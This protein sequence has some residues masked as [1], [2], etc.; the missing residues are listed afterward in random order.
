M[1][2]DSLD[3]TMHDRRFIYAGRGPS[4]VRAPRRTASAAGHGSCSPRSSYQ[5]NTFSPS[6]YPHHHAHTGGTPST[7]DDPHGSAQAF[8][9]R[10]GI[11]LHLIEGVRL[12]VA[13]WR[14]RRSSGVSAQGRAA[15]GA[16]LR[17]RLVEG[18]VLRGRLFAVLVDQ[19]RH[20]ARV[21]ASYMR[22]TQRRP[23]ICRQRRVSCIMRT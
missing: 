10:S 6:F 15:T 22:S 21:G 11:M 9:Q 20:A 17:R 23:E 5:N 16:L 4:V 1:W 8:H 18:T 19:D 14:A 3:A 12:R 2:I 13:Q 7:V